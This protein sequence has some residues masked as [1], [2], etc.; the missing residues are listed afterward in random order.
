MTC[1]VLVLI[2]GLAPLT[3]IQSDN[4]WIRRRIVVDECDAYSRAALFNVFALMCGA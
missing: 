4:A 1:T 2:I 3:L